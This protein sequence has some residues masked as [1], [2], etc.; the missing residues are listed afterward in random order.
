MRWRANTSSVEDVTNPLYHNL[1]LKVKP[2]LDQYLV[3][4][5]D[6]SATYVYPTFVKGGDI[7]IID[8][9]KYLPSSE[10]Q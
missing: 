5:L 4:W 1:I 6:D 7:A 8:L 10:Y 3:V 9:S 2:A